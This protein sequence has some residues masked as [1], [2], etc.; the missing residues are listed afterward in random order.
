MR[1]MWTSSLVAAAILLAKPAG[2]TEQAELQRAQWLTSAQY[3]QVFHKQVREGR[4]PKTVE[5]RC[6]SGREQF[7]AEWGRMPSGAGFYSHH[8]LTKAFY[9]AKNREYVSH[10]YSLQSVTN[11][12]DCSGIQRYQATWINTS[13]PLPVASSTAPD[14][15]PKPIETPAAT[16]PQKLR[17]AH[18]EGVVNIQFRVL[19][20][21]SVADVRAVPPSRQE[22]IPTVLES[23]EKWRFEPHA[24]GGD[25]GVVM[26]SSMNFHF[27]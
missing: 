7:R 19:P 15:V 23:V 22:L 11:F 6:E 16:Y 8:A 25:I 13:G 1:L 3:Q 9:E 2:A 20:D 10:G 17:R 18:I 14:C 27:K 26:Q 21:G 5:G 24:C 12:E 4:Y